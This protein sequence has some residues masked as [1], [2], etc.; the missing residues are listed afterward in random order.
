MEILRVR[1]G[2]T[3]NSSSY[4]EW[5]PPPLEKEGNSSGPKGNKSPVSPSNTTDAATQSPGTP[6]STAPVSVSNP[7]YTNALAVGG[8]VAIVVGVYLAEKIFRKK[9]NKERGEEEDE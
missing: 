3:T 8:F 7:A 2:Y 6:V 5:L 9:R 1:R 4:T